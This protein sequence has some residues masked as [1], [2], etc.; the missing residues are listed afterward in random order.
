VRLAERRELN[1]QAASNCLWAAAKLG[2]RDVGTVHALARACARV[3]PTFIAQNAANCIFAAATLGIAD[4]ALLWPLLCACVRLSDSFNS[5]DAANSLLAAAKLAVADGAVVSALAAA[6]DRLA[7]QFNAQNAAN[8]LYAAALLGGLVGSATVARL[9]GACRRTAPSFTPQNAANCL[10]AGACLTVADAPFYEAVCQA[11]V[12]APPTRVE[13]AQ[14]IL[15][16]VAASSTSASSSSFSDM[17]IPTDLAKLLP[18]SVLDRCRQLLGS[19]Q[20]RSRNQAEAQPL[21]PPRSAPQRELAATLRSLGFSVLEEAPILGGLLTVDAVFRG[22]HEKGAIS[23]PG[24]CRVAVEFDGPTHFPRYIGSA[25]DGESPRLSLG[26]R[27]PPINGSTQL[28][29]R[30]LRDVAG[31]TLVA[32]PGFEWARLRSSQAQVAYIRG[33][34]RAAGVAAPTADLRPHDATQGSGR[35]HADSS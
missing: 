13:H 9:V 4:A 17:R 6:C 1:A 27:P 26:R 10:W 14:Q 16:A 15:Q 23:V 31:M 21:P 33:R 24:Q 11:V 2:V 20:C 19:V 3:T 25:T 35:A 28:R 22:R 32:V 34:L 12:L 18:A 29:N 30:L 7:S 5:Q 8:S